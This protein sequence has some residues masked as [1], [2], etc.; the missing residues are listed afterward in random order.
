[1]G[2]EPLPVFLRYSL[3]QDRMGIATVLRALENRQMLYSGNHG[4]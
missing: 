3:G 1:M 2:C 4:I